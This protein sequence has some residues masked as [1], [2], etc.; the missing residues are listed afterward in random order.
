MGLIFSNNKFNI[1]GHIKIDAPTPTYSGK[2]TSSSD[3]INPYTAVGP[4]PSGGGLTETQIN[5]I[6]GI[7][8]ITLPSSPNFHLVPSGNGISD[9]TGHYSASAVSC[10]GTT[11]TSPGS[12]ASTS[13]LILN[14]STSYI[15]MPSYSWHLGSTNFTGT[16]CWYQ[17]GAGIAFSNDRQVMN[18]DDCRITL[19]GSG[20]LQWLHDYLDVAPYTQNVTSSVAVTNTNNWNFLAIRADNPNS[21]YTFYLNTN[22]QTKTFRNSS[23]TNTSSSN[24]SLELGRAHNY[25]YGTLYANIRLGPFIYYNRLLTDDEIMDCYYG[26]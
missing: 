5:F 6:R 12:G 4:G 9:I 26:L 1:N 16:F 21:Q 8:D 24:Y 13:G 2:K 25:T 19:G 22:T 14:G 20:T 11:F 23:P 7:G 15:N 18:V 17:Y 3:T 10:T